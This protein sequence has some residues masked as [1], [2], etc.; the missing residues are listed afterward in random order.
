MRRETKPRI[1]EDRLLL[2]LAR[3]HGTPLFVYDAATIRARIEELRGFDVIRYAQKANSNLALLSSMRAAGVRVDSVSAGEIARALR[4]GYAPSEIAFSTDLLDRAA[5]AML[6]EHPVTVNVGS[7]DML[8]QLARLGTAGSRREIVLRVNP[9]FGHGH[10]RRVSTG[11]ETSKHGIWH[12]DLGEVAVRAAALGFSVVG[13][14]VHIGSGSDLEHL[15]RACG[16]MRTHARVVAGS[17]R[18]ISAGGGIPVPYRSGEPR[19]DLV[20]LTN[21]WRETKAAIE[22]DVGRSITLEVEPGRY[23]VAEAGVLLAEVRATKRSGSYDYVLADAGFH[24][25][26]RPAMYGAWHEISVVGKPADAPTSPRVLGGP[27]CES[28]DVFTQDRQGNLD[29][30]PLPDVTEGDIVCIHD[31]GAYAA[32]MASNYN[33]QPFAAEV[34]V[35]GARARL[36]RRRQPIEDLYR[37]EEDEHVEGSA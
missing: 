32:S 25:L 30:R 20:R 7:P 33:S 31:A 23:L 28:S 37:L 24:N 4:A 34:L 11:G 27:L 8:E 13:L 9:G 6:R 1:L 22:K 18:S 35:D 16:S 3:E 36:V 2:D 15:T 26:V 19:I 29:P 12:E 14:H 5:I 17:L 21:A 10:D